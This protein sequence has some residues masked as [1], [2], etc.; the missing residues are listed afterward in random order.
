MRV[1]SVTK[2]LVSTTLIS[3]TGKKN[4]PYEHSSPGNW[5]ETFFDKIAL[6]LQKDGQNVIIMPW[7]MIM[8]MP[9]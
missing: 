7:I 8:I 3:A 1:S 9:L 4:I 6:L 2:I 5:A